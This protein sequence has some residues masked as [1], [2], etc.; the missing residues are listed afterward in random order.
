MLN[1]LGASSTGEEE[2][3]AEEED[4]AEEEAAIDERLELEVCFAG[5][6]GRVEEEELAAIASP[7]CPFFKFAFDSVFFDVL[8]D[9]DEEDFEDFPLFDAMVQ[10]VNGWPVQKEGRKPK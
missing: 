2:E 7:D 9:L 8:P 3:A 10:V 4:A 5:E 1:V 6:V